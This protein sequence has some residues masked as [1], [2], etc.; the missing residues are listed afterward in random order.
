MKTFGH[1]VEW[2]QID[3][4]LSGWKLQEKANQELTRT[5]LPVSDV[6]LEF[7]DGSI[8]VAL[9]IQKGIAIP[10][11]CA[12]TGIEV[13][14]SRIE[15][16]IERVSTFGVLPIPGSLFRFVGEMNLPDGVRFDSAEMKIVLELSKLVPGVVDLT[17]ERVRIIEG[18]LVVRLGQGG[19]DL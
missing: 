7:R 9:K 5:R 11:R 18:G 3:L 13:R 19:I 6:R 4:R 8:G 1:L 16:R 12:V 14:R 17:V 15:I 2:E 10:V